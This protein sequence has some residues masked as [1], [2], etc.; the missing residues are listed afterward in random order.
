MRW[1]YLFLTSKD[2]VRRYAPFVVV[3]PKVERPP[4]KGSVVGSIPTHDTILSRCC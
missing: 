1:K 2:I 4:E 3:A